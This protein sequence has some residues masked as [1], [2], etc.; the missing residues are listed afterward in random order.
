MPNQP[1]KNESF[2]T[3]W[4]PV[5][6]MLAVFWPVGLYLLYK[7][8]KKLSS[9]TPGKQRRKSVNNIGIG[10]IVFGALMLL[11]VVGI[12]SNVGMFAIIG[13]GALMFVG[14][15]MKKREKRFKRYQSIIGKRRTMPISDIATAMAV[16]YDQAVKDLQYMIDQEYFGS[17]AYLDLYVG[18][19]VLSAM[20]AP[21]WPKEKAAPRNAP[22]A[23]TA[24]APAAPAKSAQAK[25]QSLERSFK[26]KLAEIRKANELIEDEQV[27]HQIEKIEAITCNIFERVTEHPE[28]ISQIQTFLNYYLPTTLKLLKTYGEM[29][30]QKAAGDNIKA[31]MKDIEK[32]VDQLVWA[33][34]RQLDNLFETEAKD[35]SSDIKVLE[36]MMARDGLTDNP[37]TLPKTGGGGGAAAQAKER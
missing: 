2:D 12:G 21:E 35:I 13:G 36:R 30:R 29:E 14:D 23:Q 32:M 8:L 31:S 33:F 19:F 4:I 37:Y 11:D 7:Q 3:S 10:L 20:D 9:A 6:I 18:A 34:E 1:K 26:E 22:Q 28:R 24:Q 16:S 25:E 27:S 5:F 17:S 15:S